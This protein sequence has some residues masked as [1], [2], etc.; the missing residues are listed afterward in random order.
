MSWQLSC[1]GSL[2]ISF[3]PIYRMLSFSTVTFLEDFFFFF[4]VVEFGVCLESVQ[5]A[6]LDS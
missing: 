6:E 3:I 5:P 1:H 4:V 2:L